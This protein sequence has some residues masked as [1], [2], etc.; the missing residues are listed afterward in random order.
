MPITVT[1][2][3]QHAHLVAT[4]SGPVSVAILGDFVRTARVGDSR[5]RPMLIDARTATFE[6]TAEDLRDVIAPV[7]AQLKA[8]DGDR[9]PVAIVV[10]DR[11]AFKMARMF[12][13][14]VSAQ[15]LVHLGVFREWDAAE[16]W[17]VSIIDPRR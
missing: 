12:E 7:I 16:Q 4:A 17:L 5:L 6:M 14:L 1:R 3:D 2:D 15:G 8:A 13:T 10:E 11:A 9:A